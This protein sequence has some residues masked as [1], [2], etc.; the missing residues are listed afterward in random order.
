[1][2]RYL[3]SRLVPQ[4]NNINKP[5]LNKIHTKNVKISLA[6]TDSFNSV[7]NNKDVVFLQ[8]LNSENLNYHPYISNTDNTKV[9][10]LK[11]FINVLYTHN[12]H[13]AIIYYKVFIHLILLHRF[14]L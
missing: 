4:K 10:D 7:I 5:I 14:N 9:Q 3:T 1:M 8:N 6:Q 11:S 12:L 13:H 2:N